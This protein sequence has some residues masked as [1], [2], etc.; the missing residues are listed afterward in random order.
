M[1]DTESNAYNSD[2]E[3]IMDFLKLSIISNDVSQSG[4]KRKD[5]LN[6][7]KAM[8]ETL[9][10][11]QS[12]RISRIYSK[13]HEIYRLNR[14]VTSANAVD[15]ELERL[16]DLS[17]EISSLREEEPVNRTPPPMAAPPSMAPPTMAPPSM[18]PPPMM[19]PPMGPQ[20]MVP[21]QFNQ[22]QL[23]R[24]NDNNITR[25]R[26]VKPYQGPPPAGARVF[27]APAGT[28]G[29]VPSV[30]HVTSPVDS[31]KMVRI[32]TR[33]V[34][35]SP[36]SGSTITSRPIVS[37]TI[38]P[39]AGPAVGPVAIARSFGGPAMRPAMGPAMGPV[40][41]Q[42][43]GPVT[44]VVGS[45]GSPIPDSSSIF[46]T[47]ESDKPNR[48]V[49]MVGDA[50]HRENDR[51]M[52]IW[53]AHKQEIM[54]TPERVPIVVRQFDLRSDGDTIDALR[55]KL[56]LNPVTSPSIYRVDLS[57]GKPR[58]MRFTQPVTLGNLRDF[59]RFE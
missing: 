52:P 27:S 37:S 11:A 53:N 3:M 13:M 38:V 20:L 46:R 48:F 47:G 59:S 7:Q 58:V 30:A 34:S 19:A 57:S 33:V 23:G 50:G 28:M 54:E 36:N 6:L 24:F 40:M 43:A 55:Q 25:I 8:L 39:V 21:P 26:G 1:S 18:A 42:V 56:D 14:D 9:P 4:D 22:P 32:T 12:N 29:V 49:I 16:R 17:K 10:V 44:R 51:I 31:S 45:V 15:T 41:G 5:A 35:P 2:I